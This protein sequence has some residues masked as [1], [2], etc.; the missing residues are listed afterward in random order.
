M[1]KSEINIEQV[2]FV[3]VCSLQRTC[4]GCRNTDWGGK[5]ILEYWSCEDCKCY[6]NK[7]VIKIIKQLRDNQAKRGEAPNDIPILAYLK[8]LDAK[9]ELFK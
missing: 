6:D 7:N 9:G 8:M 1:S 4:I 5:Q 3:N 2:K